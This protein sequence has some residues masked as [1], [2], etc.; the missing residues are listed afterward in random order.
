MW[1][2]WHRKTFPG[3]H[4]GTVYRF[5]VADRTKVTNVEPVADG[6][7]ELMAV[8][9]LSKAHQATLGQL[10]YEAF[11]TAARQGWILGAAI[12]GE[13]AGYIMFRPRK[14]DGIVVITHLCVATHKR[15]RGIARQLVDA[16]SARYPQSP[17]LVLSCRADY[18]ATAQWPRLGFDRSGRKQGRSKNGHEL[19]RWWRP[20]D[21]VNLFTYRSERE[22]LPAAAL[23]T[24]VFR[25]IVQPRERYTN[26]IS[27]DADWLT[28][29]IELVTT[30]QLG[31]EIDLAAESTPGLRGTTTRYR[32]L[33]AAPELWEPIETD[34]HTRLLGSGVGEGD[35][36][37]LAQ[38]AAGGATYFV[39]RDKAIL[40]KATTI[41]D[42]TGLKVVAPA[43]VS[44]TIHADQYAMQ[45]RPEALHESDY[46]LR[47]PSKLPTL[48]QLG[49]FVDRVVDRKA[50]TLAAAF[51]VLGASVNAGG[52]LWELSDPD[53]RCVALA[54]TNTSSTE[55]VVSVLRVRAS[56]NRETFARQLLHRFREEAVHC[57]K[58]GV[59]LGTPTPTYLDSALE[60]EG[61]SNSDGAW[62][63][64][65]RQGTI[66]P[67]DLVPDLEPRVLA[68]DL[69][70]ESV[71]MLERM[72]W[73]L[74]IVSGNVPTYVVP[75]QPTWARALFDE[76][77]EQLELLRRPGRLGVAREHVYYCSLKTTLVAP[78]RLLWWVSGRGPNSGMRAWSWLDHV[79]HERPRTLFKR[80]GAQGIYQQ[81]DVEALA[82]APGQRVTALVFSRTELFARPIKLAQARALHPEMRTNGYLQTAKKVGEHVFVSFLQH[83]STQ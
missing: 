82:R 33:R 8:I 74:K 29:F 19:V 15:G 45:Y 10:P 64:D 11:H 43:D 37:N 35:R 18:P 76:S 3:R 47:H 78:A 72:M 36:R 17:G 44:L 56:N 2:Q 57:G 13:L 30:A 34:L 62:R 27:L 28:E 71:S 69:Q 7:S 63:A 59:S 12:D 70:P 22:N 25:D 48:D 46:E 14:R 77:P 5:L 52:R 51:N 21:E 65:C 40:A 55:F 67:D 75:I 73:P 41:E 9:A 80:F 6:G 81:S 24:D 31:S 4:A 26:S 68:R 38:A 39:T 42:S 83:G 61:Y 66:E 23:D 1:R 49:P 60:V 20:I 50:N 53:G 54:L 79:A 16:L 58:S 32:T